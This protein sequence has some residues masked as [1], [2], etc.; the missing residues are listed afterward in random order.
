MNVAIFVAKVLSLLYLSAGLAALSGKVT[1]AKIVDDFDKSP[2]LTFMTGLITLT[3]GMLILEFH[4]VWVK[5]WTVLVTIVGWAAVLK[6]IM[7]IAFP[8]ALSFF[9]P[10]YK[11]SQNWAI[12]LLAIGALFGYFGFIA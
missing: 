11:N 2:A 9:K 8:N 7:F 5:D 12:L 4:N 6:G 1:F 10:W 3:M